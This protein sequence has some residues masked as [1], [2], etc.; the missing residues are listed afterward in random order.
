M[1]K[2]TYAATPEYSEAGPYLQKY[3]GDI[4][5]LQAFGRTGPN[6]Q[7]F[8]K[9]GRGYQDSLSTLGGGMTS[10]FEG[11]L[12]YAGRALDEGFDPQSAFYLQN[13][14]DLTDYT[15]S[16]EAARGIAMTPYGAAV[17]ANTQGRFINDWRDRQLARQHMGA[18]TADIL[19]GRTQSSQEAGG[20]LINDAG[21]L[22]IDMMTQMLQKYG[23]QGAQLQAAL[24]AM[25]GLGAITLKGAELGNVNPLTGQTYRSPYA[26]ITFDAGSATQSG[27]S[28]TGLYSRPASI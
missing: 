9:R 12:P 7:P 25:Q 8:Q 13:L 21:K 3:Q 28:P 1:A 19:Q 26:G 15:R 14:Q 18:Q 2:G 10:Q 22:N 11:N 24:Q 5:G 16:G 4:A 6:T 27:Y 23:L 17:E 20:R